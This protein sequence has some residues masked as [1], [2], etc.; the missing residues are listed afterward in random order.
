[1]TGQGITLVPL[2]GLVGH[3]RVLLST[4]RLRPSAVA[5]PGDI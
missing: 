3:D 4:R 1:M 2:G 5:V